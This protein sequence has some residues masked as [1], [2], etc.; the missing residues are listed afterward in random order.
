MSGKSSVGGLL[1]YGSSSSV[2]NSYWTPAQ[3]G[4]TTS[5]GGISVETLAG[6]KATSLYTGWSQ[7]IWTIT[8]GQL[9]QLK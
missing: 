9:P 5:S 2:T 1:G 7:T 8:E 3:A 6:M 4:V